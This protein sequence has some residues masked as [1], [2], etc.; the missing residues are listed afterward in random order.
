MTS[1]EALEHTGHSPGRRRMRAAAALA[2]A[3]CAVGLIAVVVR[4][5]AAQI[6][7]ALAQY[8]SFGPGGEVGVQRVRWE[9]LQ[10]AQPTSFAAAR[11]PQH[12][13]L[14]HMCFGGDCADVPPAFAKALISTE[15]G[16]Y[17]KAFHAGEVAVRREMTAAKP[18]QVGNII[19]GMRPMRVATMKDEVAKHERLVAAGPPKPAWHSQ[20][21][22]IFGAHKKNPFGG[23]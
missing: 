1:M 7:S 14:A 13:L 8:T 20:W 17:A 6:G 5:D 2:A 9:Q 23:M 4:Q 11:Q 15:K 21:E 16:A 19:N 18:H 3:A 12:D 10:A 22:K